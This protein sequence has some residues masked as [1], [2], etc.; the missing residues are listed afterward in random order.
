MS[1]TLVVVDMQGCFD[2]ANNPNVVIGVT[3]EIMLAKQ[4]NSPI[5]L[6]EYEGC[7]KSHEG[8]SNLL[9]NYPWKTRVKK[10]DDDGSA[11]VIKALRRRGFSNDKLRLC[12]VNTDACVYATAEGLLKK[13][14][15]SQIEVVKNA[16][17]CQV[18]GDVDW[19]KYL[20]HPNLKLV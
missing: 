9:R 6:L 1:A 19:R 3:Q 11:E 8:F 2:A 17:G 4:Q 12:G 20:R 18:V 5:V 15:D 13:L 14:S 10:T 7:G 16:C